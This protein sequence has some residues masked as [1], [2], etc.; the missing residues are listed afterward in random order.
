MSI[1]FLDNPKIKT[2]NKIPAEILA[3]ITCNSERL[4]YEDQNLKTK[5]ESLHRFLNNKLKLPPL[6]EL[7][8]SDESFFAEVNDMRR[9]RI[10]K[11][12]EKWR[13]RKKKKRRSRY[14]I[15]HLPKKPNY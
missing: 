3:Y 4:I 8:Q 14:S 1:H 9:K 15:K 10:R 13:L 5:T 11:E 2:R 12:T 7:N 6:L